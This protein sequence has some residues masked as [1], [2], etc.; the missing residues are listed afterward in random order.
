MV[1]ADYAE[2][3][4]RYDHAVLGDAIEWGALRLRHASGREVLLRLPVHRVFEDLAPRLVSL[5]SGEVAAMVVESD[6]GRGAR[7]A[8]Y[9]SGGLIAAAPFIGQRHRWLA[10]VGAGD[11]DGDGRVELAYVDRPHLAKILRIWRHVPGR[12][13][14]EEVAATPGF[15]N[16]RIGRDRIE[17]G[18]RDCGAGPEMIVARADWSRIAAA[19]LVGG[20]IEARD[21]GPYSERDMAAALQ[22]RP[23][24]A[25]APR[26]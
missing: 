9:G 13:A 1:A 3:T 15:T 14:L 18:L 8:L 11:L 24:R 10:P 2:P 20:R 23:G 6:L 16:H 22:C 19:R 12:A 21:L 25:A 7:L 4:T 5:A 17:G 26:P